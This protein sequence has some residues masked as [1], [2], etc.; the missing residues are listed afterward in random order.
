MKKIVLYGTGRRGKYYAYQLYKQGIEVAAFCDSFNTETVVYE[1]EGKS[2]EKPVWNIEDIDNNYHIIIAIGDTDEA[3]KVREKIKQYGIPITTLEKIIHQGKD[4]VSNNRV[5]I[6]EF[7]NDEMG[8]YF[9]SAEDES[10]IDVFWNKNSPFRLL[11]CELDL[12]KVVELACGQ[13]RHVPQYIS[14]SQEIILVD[15]LKKNIEYCKERFRGENN[16]SYYINNGYDLKQLDSESVT[17][18]F[19]YDAMVH[20]EMMDIFQYLK[21]TRRILVPGGKALFHHS[22]N[23]EDYK[24]TF[25]TGRAGRNYM[26]K[27]LFA[28]LADR[29]GL[30]VVKQKEISWGGYERLDCITLVEKRKD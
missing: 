13:G 9:V 2:I 25:L 4:I 28:H 26:S 22:N 6:A 19:T 16:I 18:L 1:C 5:L 24:I 12:K 27:S 29:A 11:F 21:E 10:K 14:D 17:A 23:T 7:H 8:D 20:F 3:A 30:S 15:I